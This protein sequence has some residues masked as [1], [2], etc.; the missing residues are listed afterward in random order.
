MHVSFWRSLSSWSY[1][2]L[3]STLNTAL[4]QITQTKASRK[5]A[6]SH[7]CQTTGQTDTETSGVQPRS[8]RRSFSFIN[9]SIIC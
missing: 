3:T 7:N 9:V 2:S 1:R 6:S 4:S 5:D 8:S